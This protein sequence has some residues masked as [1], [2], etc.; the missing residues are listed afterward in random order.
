[1]SETI[2][3]QVWADGGENG[4]SRDLATLAVP[5]VGRLV[6]T[7]DRWEPYGLVDSDGSK[8]EAVAAWFADLQAGGRSV[9]TVRSYGADLL[10]WFRFLWAVGVPWERATRGEARDFSRWLVVAG[11]PPRPHWRHPDE[12]A[13]PVPPDS[14][15]AASACD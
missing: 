1:M 2:E 14:A 15:Y 5:L 10:R 13:A 4:G 6:G 3:G 12:P 7:D 9:A 8:V 11:K